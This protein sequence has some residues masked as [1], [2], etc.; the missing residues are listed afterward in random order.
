MLLRCAIARHVLRMRGGGSC[1]KVLSYVVRGGTVGFCYHS[2]TLY[3]LGNTRVSIQ[4][5]NN[6]LNQSR[7]YYLVIVTQQ[8]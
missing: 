6:I 1:L 7:L 4:V 2:V 8:V 3:K 5:L